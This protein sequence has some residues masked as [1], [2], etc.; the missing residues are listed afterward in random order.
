MKEQNA[1]TNAETKNHRAINE[2]DTHQL[3]LE[4]KYYC[5]L[6]LKYSLLR[7]K[8]QLTRTP[9][10]TEAWQSPFAPS[11]S[12]QLLTYRASALT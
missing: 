10:Q 9:V 7:L 5:L 1:E 2:D 3:T 11:K 6:H 12:L 4:D 8:I